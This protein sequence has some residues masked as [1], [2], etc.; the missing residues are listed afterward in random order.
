VFRGDRGVARAARQRP[1]SL[2]LP[3]LGALLAAAGGLALLA[4]LDVVDVPLDVTLAAGVVLVGVLV[5]VGAFF[6]RAAGLVL[7]GLVLAAGLAVA[8]LA[9]LGNGGP[10]GDRTYGPASVSELRHEY[11]LRIGDLNVDL[12]ALELPAGETRVDV[13][14][15]MGNVVI[16]V[17]R[18]VTVDATADAGVGEVSVF[19]R[20]QSGWDARE[21]AVEGAGTGPRLVID[22][23]VG[24]GHI[25]IRPAG[26]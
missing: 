26:L 17:P 12:R 3:G 4:V 5:A 14:A 20:H 25:E 9:S 23:H 1:R 21:R 8:S 13:N 11:K 24:M 16:R 10:I 6:H 2:F 7:L 15:G 19:D 22:A 18:G